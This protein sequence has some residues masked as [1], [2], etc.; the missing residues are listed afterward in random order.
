MIAFIIG[1]D[2]YEVHNDEQM[3]ALVRRAVPKASN[4]YV[5]S[6]TQQEATDVIVALTGAK[7][8]R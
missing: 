2:V 3:R 4:G 1:D 7:V 5:L 8:R 6:L